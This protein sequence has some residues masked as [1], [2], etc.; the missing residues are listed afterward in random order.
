LLF[1]NYLRSTVDSHLHFVHVTSSRYMFVSIVVI[2]LSFVF[3]FCFH[4]EMTHDFLVVDCGTNRG[5]SGSRKYKFDNVHEIVDPG[6][7]LCTYI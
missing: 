7:I 4:Y 6:L 1:L 2:C 5:K 3:I